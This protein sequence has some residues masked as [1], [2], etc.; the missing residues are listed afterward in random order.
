MRAR[1]FEQ[2]KPKNLAAK[3]KKNPTFVR[4]IRQW[5]TGCITVGRGA[6]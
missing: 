4:S 1:V 6:L 2:A 3:K 5:R